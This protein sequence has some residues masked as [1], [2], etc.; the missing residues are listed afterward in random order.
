MAQ[1]KITYTEA[2]SKLQEILHLLEEDDQDV[3]GLSEKIKE[4]S[5]LLNI[6]KEKLFTIDEEI[7]KALEDLK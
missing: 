2:Y 1:K 5:A 6:C 7:K 4:A 3:D